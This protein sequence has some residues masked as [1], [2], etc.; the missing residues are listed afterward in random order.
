MR[1]IDSADA[2]AAAVASILNVETPPAPANPDCT[3]YATD[4]IEKF[5]RLGSA[6]LGR[7]LPAVNLI[8]LGG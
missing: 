3:F 1:I 7:P 8:D 2:T 6:F 5:Q 4:S